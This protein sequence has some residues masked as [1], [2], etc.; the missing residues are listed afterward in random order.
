VSGM[1]LTRNRVRF[2]V[3]VVVW[4]I[5]AGL[6][7]SVLPWHGWYLYAYLG[8]VVVIG[9]VSAAVEHREKKLLAED[10]SDQKD[11]DDQKDDQ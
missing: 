6:L 1:I 4:V 8:G 5:V 9:L 2:S 10:F 11:E 3:I 7:M